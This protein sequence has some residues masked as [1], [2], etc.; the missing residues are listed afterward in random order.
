MTKHLTTIRLDERLKKG[1]QKKAKKYGLTFSDI[2]H[3]LLDAFVTGEVEVGVTKYPIKYLK[4]INKE[5]D[6]MDRLRRAGKLKS[7]ASAK[8]MFKAILGDDWKKKN[9]K[10]TK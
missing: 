7:Y 1:V 3:L 4:Q 2:V 9:R 5:I 8:E 6:E 10:R